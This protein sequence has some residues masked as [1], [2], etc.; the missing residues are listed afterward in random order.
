MDRQS[1]LSISATA[2]LAMVLLPG[3]AVSQQQTPKERLIKS[4]HRDA[5]D[6]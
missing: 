6:R 2:A 3:G 1:I 4:E 5:H